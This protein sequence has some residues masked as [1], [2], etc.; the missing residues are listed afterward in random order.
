MWDALSA[1][2]FG[3]I[4]DRANLKG[5]LVRLYLALR[6]DWNRILQNPN[7]PNWRTT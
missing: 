3:V 4:I 6:S 1:P 2:I 5:G 7:E